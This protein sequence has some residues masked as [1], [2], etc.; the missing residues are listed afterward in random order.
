M[1]LWGPSGQRLAWSGLP[2]AG[3]VGSWGP[4]LLSLGWACPLRDSLLG[5]IEEI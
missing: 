3:A 2:A 5:G 4:G 1:S